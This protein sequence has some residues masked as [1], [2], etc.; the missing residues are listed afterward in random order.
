MCVCIPILLPYELNDPKTCALSLTPTLTHS[1]SHSLT[2]IYSLPLT[3]SHSL[4]PILQL[5]LTHSHSLTH[6]HFHSLTHSPTHS[7][8]HSLTHPLINSPLLFPK[9]VSNMSCANSFSIPEES[10]QRIV[11]IPPEPLNQPYKQCRMDTQSAAVE[12]LGISY[13]STTLV[14]VV[15]VTGFVYLLQ[16]V[17]SLYCDVQNI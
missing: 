2:S 1:H 15:L 12:A 16:I 5:P 6:C 8:T 9:T 14:L 13:G 4:T 3:H 7:L 10:F 17:S 11:Q